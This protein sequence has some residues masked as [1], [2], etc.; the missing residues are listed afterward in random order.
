MTPLLR[1]HWPLLAAVA[2]LWGSVALL[3]VISIR[4]NEGH[5]VY[6]LDDA[7]IHLA[8]VKNVVRHGVWG[9]TPYGWTSSSS[10]L[11]WSLVLCGATMLAGLNDATPLVLNLVF[12]T[13]LLGLV[14]RLLREGQDMAG[15]ARTIR[16][17]I[18]GRGDPARVDRGLTIG[19]RLPTGQILETGALLAFIFLTPLPALILNGMEHVLQ[20]GIDLLFACAAAR[21]V[22]GEDRGLSSPVFR[23]LLAA[24]PFTTLVRYEGLFLL[25]AAGLLLACRRRWAQA[26]VVSIAGLLPVA[27]YALISTSGGWFWLPNPVMLKGDVAF[28]TIGK[29]FLVLCGYGIFRKMDMGAKI[30][31]YLFFLLVILMLVLFISRYDRLKGM[32]EE[33]QIFIALTGLTLW[34]HVQFANLGSFYR[35]EAYLVA[36]GVFLAA[37]LGL[38]FIHSGGPQIRIRLDRALL[39]KHAAVSCLVLLAVLPLTARGFFALRHAA[40]ATTNIYEQQY[41]MGLFLR[42]FYEGESVAVNDIGA[43]NYLADIKCLDLIGLA[44]IEVARMKKAHLFSQASLVALVKARAT[45]I[46]IVYEDWFRFKTPEGRQALPPAWV[47]VGEWTISHRVSSYEPTVAF[48]ALAPGEEPVLRAHLTAFASRLPPTVRQSLTTSDLEPRA[49]LR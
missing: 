23:G 3:L 43:I 33:R 35:Y 49:A 13:L 31:E 17:E 22:A 4:Q 1:K 27:V 16:I 48:Y 7:Y 38:D 26:A 28:M 29:M 39:A 10:S 6:A 5:L 37:R 42:Q 12:S 30:T 19:T 47:K 36:F 32:W 40:R 20:V 45:R 34:L 11:L 46:A 25:F 41:Q 44:D 8:M 24:A 9:V 2:A 15:S 18:L 21:L 14:S